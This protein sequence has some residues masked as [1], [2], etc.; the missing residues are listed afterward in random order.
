M[1]FDWFKSN[2]TEPKNDENEIIVNQTQ[3]NNSKEKYYIESCWSGN[4]WYITLYQKID[5]KEHDQSIKFTSAESE[6]DRDHII[7]DYK[8]NKDRYIQDYK[9]KTSQNI[10]IPL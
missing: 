6:R 7:R 5:G 9:N 10:Q 2:K 1:I 4:Y 3:C 8:L